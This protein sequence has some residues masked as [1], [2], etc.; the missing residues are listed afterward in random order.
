MGLFLLLTLCWHFNYNVKET[1]ENLYNKI[2]VIIYFI[3]STIK[4]IVCEVLE[5]GLITYVKEHYSVFINKLPMEKL[6]DIWTRIKNAVWDFYWNPYFGWTFFFLYLFLLFFFLWLWI[7]VI[8]YFIEDPF[9]DFSLIMLDKDFKSLNW[10]QKIKRLAIK[11]F[12]I[13]SFLNEDVTE[14]Y[15]RS[16]LEL[17]PYYIKNMTHKEILEFFEDINT[18]LIIKSYQNNNKYENY[19][20]VLK[21]FIYFLKRQEEMFETY[22]HNTEIFQNIKLNDI[23]Y[24]IMFSS[25]ASLQKHHYLT[26]QGTINNLNISIIPHILNYV[27]LTTDKDMEGLVQRPDG[28]YISRKL[29]TAEYILTKYKKYGRDLPLSADEILLPFNKLFKLLCDRVYDKVFEQFAY[30][31]WMAE[32]QNYTLEAIGEYDINGEWIEYFHRRY[33]SEI[34]WAFFDGTCTRNDITYLS[35]SS[36]GRFVLNYNNDLS[37]LSKVVPVVMKERLSEYLWKIIY[38]KNLP[39]PAD[40]EA[41]KWLALEKNTAW[42][43]FSISVPSNET[44]KQG[45]RINI[46]AYAL[47]DIFWD[48]PLTK[49]KPTGYINGFYEKMCNK[50]DYFVEVVLEERLRRIAVW[51]LRSRDSPELWASRWTNRWDFNAMNP[52]YKYRLW[53]EDNTFWLTVPNSFSIFTFLQNSKE[54]L[55]FSHLSNHVSLHYTKS[56]V[57]WKVF[58]NFKLRVDWM[59]TPTPTHRYGILEYVSYLF[60][61]KIKYP[62]EEWLLTSYRTEYTQVKLLQEHFKAKCTSESYHAGYKHIELL[63]QDRLERAEISC[64][65]YLRLYIFWPL[66]YPVFYSDSSVSLLRIVC[67]FSH[68]FCFLIDRYVYTLNVDFT[69][70]FKVETY[71]DSIVVVRELPFGTNW[72]ERI[73]DYFSI[74][75]NFLWTK[76]SDKLITHVNMYIIAWKQDQWE[77]SDLIKTKHNPFVPRSPVFKFYGG[78]YGHDIN[79]RRELDDQ[80]LTFFLKGYHWCLSW[81]YELELKEID[82][83]SPRFKVFDRNALRFSQPR[84]AHEVEYIYKQLYKQ[85]Y[86][87]IPPIYEKFNNFINWT[88]NRKDPDASVFR[89][90]VHVY[91]LAD[92]PW[93]IFWLW[94]VECV[95]IPAFFDYCYEDEEFLLWFRRIYHFFFPNFHNLSSAYTSFNDV[96]YKD[97]DS[98]NSHI[99]DIEKVNKEKLEHLQTRMKEWTNVIDEKRKAHWEDFVDKR[100]I[101]SLLPLKDEKHLLTRLYGPDYNNWYVQKR[102]YSLAEYKFDQSP[103]YQQNF[104]KVLTFIIPWYNYGF[105]A[106]DLAEEMGTVYRCC[107][108]EHVILQKKNGNEIL[109]IFR[110]VSIFSLFEKMFVD[111]TFESWLI[112]LERRYFTSEELVNKLFANWAEDNIDFNRWFA[113]EIESYDIDL[114]A[115]RLSHIVFPENE[116]FWRIP[117]LNI[118]VDS[119]RASKYFRFARK[120]LIRQR[121]RTFDSYVTRETVGLP[122]FKEKNNNQRVFYFDEIDENA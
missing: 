63:K 34:P 33:F 62:F 74:W 121:Y 44:S 98:L 19:L 43:V 9:L 71:Q 18:K 95:I 72:I 54:Y 51:L 112:G 48:H 22:M 88:V 61:L 86:M 109:D 57:W 50:W 12:I 87:Y 101:F 15:A 70:N 105:S 40:I 107:S 92:S 21:N 122:S 10:D 103:E 60:C 110:N 67:F 5:K 116:S 120:I 25:T 2:K 41:P 118:D 96:Y 13:G 106:T 85:W 64:F 1:V 76:W 83:Y 115:T 97:L 38:I 68:I 82:P 114:L 29:T 102:S 36:V 49:P 4:V 108:K 119:V 75:F 55:T 77:P 37:R 69:S 23:K 17:K 65:M 8:S 94:A 59:W 16:N 28:V 11:T 91:F 84:P 3:N 47:E 90:I 24:D 6:K 73:S 7:L 58:D 27:E 56:G 26:Q 52:T 66:F 45:V 32:G 20:L 93:S 78:I 81:F 53:D 100:T 80:S 14:A 35:G 39:I 111:V 31:A 42:N 30:D 89:D 113:N 117:S 99:K 46:F 79:V 104:K